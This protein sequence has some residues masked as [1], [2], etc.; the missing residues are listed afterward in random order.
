[1]QALLKY[2]CS[3]QDIGRAIKMISNDE[4]NHLA[5]CHEELLSLAAA[6]HADFIRTRCA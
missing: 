2:A 5:Y 4:D 1:M 3:R 6:G